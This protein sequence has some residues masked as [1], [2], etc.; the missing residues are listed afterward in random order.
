ML[1]AACETID[2]LHT[3]HEL[4]DLVNAAATLHLSKGMKPKQATSLGILQDEDSDYKFPGVDTAF[5][6]PRSKNP[7][8]AS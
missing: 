1:Q 4:C 3:D 6:L 5:A 7:R 2:S 8:T